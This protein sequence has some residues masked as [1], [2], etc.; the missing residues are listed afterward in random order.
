MPVTARPCDPSVVSTLAESIVAIGLQTL[1]TVIERGGRYVLVT[2]RHRIEA[3]KSLGIDSVPVQAVEM[4]DLEARMWAISEN[5]HRAELTDLLR[6]EQI[7]EYAELAEQKR[8]AELHS[9]QVAQNEGKRE[10]GRG[11]RHEGGDAL[12][13]RDL[14]VTRDKVR[15]AKI[16][17][18]LA[19]ETKQAARDAGLDD[20]QSALL[21]AAKASTPEAQVAALRDI[22]AQ[23]RVK[24]TPVH[25]REPIDDIVTRELITKCAGPKWLTLGKMSST[26]RRAKAPIKDALNRLGDAVKTRTGNRDDEY[27]IEGDREQLLVRAGLMTG[28]RSAA[29]SSAVIASLRAQLAD[30]NAEIERLKNALHE[31]VVEIIAAKLAANGETKPTVDDVVTAAR[32][33]AFEIKRAEPTVFGEKE[34]A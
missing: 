33:R 15:R 22:K 7:A 4:D 18:G 34:I 23:G 27:L 11:H 16:I 1:P 29:D 14:G 3:L 31:K 9:A 28:H 2:G 19:E 24:K 20:N 12:A 30:A 13:A 25:S 21:K 26:I 5:L 17:T 6:S 8:N 32:G 10:D